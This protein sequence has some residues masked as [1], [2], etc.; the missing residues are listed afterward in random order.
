[1]W[2]AREVIPRVYQL[3]VGQSS[4]FLLLEERVTVVDA[5]RRG[6]GRRVLDYLSHLGRSP[7]E[8]S[9]IVSTHYHL[10]HIGGMEHL[11]QNSPGRVAVHEAE[12]SFVQGEKPLPNPYQNPLMALL[13]GP[14]VS[15]LSPRPV[16]VDFSLR[17]G[18][19]LSPMGGMQIIHT[20]GHTPGSISLYFPQTGLL[21]AGDALQYRRGQL[22]PPSRLFTANMAQ[23]RASIRRLASLNVE[24][25]CLSHFP[26]LTK[27]VAPALRSFAETL[28]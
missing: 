1:M 21:I 3:P 10:D 22:E 19:Q 15:L 7:D 27:G 8:I 17:D 12:V 5:G 9:F 14:L 25:L 2:R 26:P 4:V 20:P 28:D 16:V 23:A 24:V 18:E 6:A 11:Q 13:M